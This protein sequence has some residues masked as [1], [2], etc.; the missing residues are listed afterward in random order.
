M[1][2]KMS[3]TQ[4]KIKNKTNLFHKK[5]Y[6]KV[7]Y[8]FLL[9][10]IIAFSWMIFSIY[11]SLPWVNDLGMI[12]T[13]PVAI[14]IIAGIGYIPG[15]INA[16]IVTSLLMDRQPRFLETS[17]NDE[18]TIIIACKNEERNIANT[19]RYIA[20]Q[21]YDGTINVIVVDNGSTDNTFYS[22]KAAG[23]ELSL[24]IQVLYEKKPG[25]YN[26]LNSALDYITTEYTVTL[27]ADT[28]LHK[29][30]IRY[31]VS[32]IKSAPKEVC[33][34]AGTVLVRNSRENFIA[35][36]QE[37]DY[38]LGI[39][40]IKRMQGLYQGT[41]VAQGAYSLYKTEALR[42]MEGWPDAIGEDIVL[43][44]NF[45]KHDL[46][47]YFEPLAVAFTDVPITLKH[48]SRQRSRWARGMLEALKIVK[49]WQHPIFYVRYFTGI[50][51][52]MPYLDFV[53][54]FCWM[55]GLIL[56]M[57][58][59]FWVVGPFTLFVMPLA[60]FQNFILYRYQRHIFK[61]LGLRVR[62]NILGFVVYV[63]MYQ[64]IMSPMSIIGYSQEILNL[65]RKWK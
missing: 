18:V 20:N 39:A 37:W 58:G 16:F 9:S 50:N 17:P 23:E 42:L 27:D 44:W 8:K 53:Y 47:V 22:A 48:L 56:A 10:H 38:F 52:L 26:A 30:A 36:L 65:R 57:F 12:V 15:Y 64:M 19:L 59:G 31:I 60:L 7:P 28:L 40:S 24:N 43:T 61:R 29:S 5:V 4:T 11:V 63:L 45:L 25:K 32:R 14:L 35:K 21:D 62:R 13:K 55:P 6:I 46:K 54:T 1:E 41:L 51:L 34:V 2:V 3:E 33:A 49:P